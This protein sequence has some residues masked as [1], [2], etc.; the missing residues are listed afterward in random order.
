M[1]G[2]M[3]RGLRKGNGLLEPFIRVYLAGKIGKSDWRHNV[4]PG[5]SRANQIEMG[6]GK[7]QVDSI[8]HPVVL[9]LQYVG[10]FFLSCDHGCFHGVSGHGR[11]VKSLLEPLMDPSLDSAPDAACAECG[12]SGTDR[13]PREVFEKCRGWLREADIVFA[14]IDSPDAFGTL[15]EIGMAVEMG[16]PTFLATSEEAARRHQIPLHMWFAAT[17]V[18]Q[19]T[20]VVAPDVMT[21]WW[22][23]VADIPK[24]LPGRPVMGA[25]G[26]GGRN[27]SASPFHCA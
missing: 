3:E 14:W 27:A 1:H 24:L 21:A 25:A 19:R 7:E 18:G 17:A 4:F 2:V 16:K 23:F 20:F 8:Q 9:N 12:I 22:W 26:A 15:V 6:Q 10:P 11:G 5:L 13:S